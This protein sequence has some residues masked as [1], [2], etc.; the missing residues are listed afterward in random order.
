MC[1]R[2]MRYLRWGG[3]WWEWR[4]NVMMG[5]GGKKWHG[6]PLLKF[7]IQFMSKVKMENCWLRLKWTW[8]L[9]FFTEMCRTANNF[10][11]MYSRK[12]ISQISF[13]HFQSHLWYSVINYIIPKRIMKTRFEPRPPGMSSWKNNKFHTLELNSGSLHQKQGFCYWTINARYIMSPQSCP[14]QDPS[15]GNKSAKPVREGW[16][17]RM[18]VLCSSEWNKYFPEWN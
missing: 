12:R 7:P 8:L 11:L 18:T 3:G 6:R 16:P 13:M 5:R 14:S 1:R 10:G 9:H 15:R 4:I 17:A 2:R